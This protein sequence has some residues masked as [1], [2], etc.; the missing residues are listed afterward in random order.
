MSKKRFSDRP[1]FLE[2]L[3]MGLNLLDR[4]ERRINEPVNVS[5]QSL[6]YDS[7]IFKSS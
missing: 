2:D 4:D 1:S 3:T 7:C 5:L 6:P